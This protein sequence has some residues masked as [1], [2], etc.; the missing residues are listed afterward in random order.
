MAGRR[1]EPGRAA[2]LAAL[3]L[4]LLAVGCGPSGEPRASSPAATPTT[5]APSTAVDPRTDTGAQRP[6]VIGVL[7]DFGV[8]ANPVR[9]VV[10]A[11]GRFNSGRP[12]DAVFTTGD[13]AYCCGTA[14]QADFA[15]RM[16]APLRL[17]GTPIYAA[18]GNHD[19]RTGDGAPLLA[20]FHARRWYTAEVGPVQFV[21]LDSNQVTS[22]TQLTFLKSV[23]AKPRPGSF[24][25]V[26]F[27]HPGWACS[28]HGP[29]AN[30]VKYWLPLFGTKVDLVLAGHNH[31]YERFTS[32][33]GTPYVTTGGGGA[34]LY[35]SAAAAC[36]GSGRL[37]FLKTAHH[38][39]RLTATET[40]LRLDAIGVDGVTFDSLVARRRT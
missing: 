28:A 20:R 15:W 35:S 2:G 11:M 21:V 23:L 40:S 32:G 19:V 39:L 13:N 5:T 6:Y 4:T 3:A 31:S 34:P 38:A 14:E 22:T 7:G 17:A 33:S 18:L 12:L 30:V 9:Q 25:V 1:R 10:K 24:R 37:A 29:D 36:R 26:L 27:H 16:L 8:D